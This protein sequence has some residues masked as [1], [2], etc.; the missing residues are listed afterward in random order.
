MKITGT[1]R[2]SLTVNGT[3]CGIDLFF[4]PWVPSVNPDTIKIRPKSGAFPHA[5]RAALEVEN[6]SD[7]QTDY[8]ESDTVRL[9][10]GHPLYAS[11]NKLRK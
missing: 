5:V 11:A 7:G 4:G 9:Q 1:K 8:F 3:R 10:P 2:L 6:N